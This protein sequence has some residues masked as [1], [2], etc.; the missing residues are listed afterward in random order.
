MRV[1][2]VSTPEMAEKLFRFR[3]E[4]YVFNL[5]WFRHDDYPDGL[6]RDSFDEVSHNYAA[7]DSQEIIIGSIRITK[8]SGDSGHHPPDIGVNNSPNGHAFLP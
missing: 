1:V 5:K 2:Y 7:L 4:M 8:D 6:V 3:Y